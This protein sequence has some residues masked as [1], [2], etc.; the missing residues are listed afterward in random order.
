MEKN[1]GLAGFRKG[2]EELE[3][4]EDD[5][6]PSFYTGET[7]SSEGE[8]ERDEEFLGYVADEVKAKKE[9]EDAIAFQSRMEDMLIPG[10]GQVTE[11]LAAKKDGTFQ[12]GRLPNDSHG[13]ASHLEFGEE[14]DVNR[15]QIANEVTTKDKPEKSYSGGRKG[16]E[17]QGRTHERHQEKEYD[18]S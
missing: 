6:I 11:G 9:E 1:G 2:R 4:G 15:Y 17:Q 8:D 16:Q 5:V 13:Y 12:K 14:T 10:M 3:A 7:A 18:K